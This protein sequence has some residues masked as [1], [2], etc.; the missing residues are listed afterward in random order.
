MRSQHDLQ[1]IVAVDES[2]GFAKK[3]E[4]PW[5]YKEDWDHFKAVTKGAICIMGRRTYEDILSK[6][7]NPDKVKKLLAGRTCYVITSNPNVE[8]FKGVE[9]VSTSVRQ[10]LDK[11]P[12]E[13]TQNIFILG[14][15]KL[16]I[17]EIVWASRI[18]MT[19]VPGRH[20]CDRHFPV[21]Y[22]SKKFVIA[23]GDK[24]KVDEGDLY[25]VRYDRARP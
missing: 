3:G 12:D 22:V 4:I 15:E 21:D 23:E 14:G 7:K 24:K 11:I 5:N 13:N 19:V 1:M 9:G 10:I 17:Q 16:Y 8:D 2:G 25:F 20:G 6:K 18:H